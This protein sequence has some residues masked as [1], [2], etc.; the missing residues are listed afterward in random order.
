MSSLAS[1]LSQLLVSGG[2]W[3]FRL[4]SAE[5]QP[6]AAHMG[7]VPKSDYGGCRHMVGFERMRWVIRRPEVRPKMDADLCPNPARSGS[8]RKRVSRCLGPVWCYASSRRVWREHVVL[9]LNL[10]GR[11]LCAR[12]GRTSPRAMALERFACV[13]AGRFPTGAASAVRTGVH[14]QV[15]AR[16][17]PW[18]RRGAGGGPP[19]APSAA[20]GAHPRTRLRARCGCER[21]GKCYASSRPIHCTTLVAVRP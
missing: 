21:R 11:A 8:G 2:M 16:L 9:R 17:P 15:R 3:Q 10:L 13:P 18:F 6:G 20:R 1:Y 12:C 5:R 4:L 14:S 7:V 19:W